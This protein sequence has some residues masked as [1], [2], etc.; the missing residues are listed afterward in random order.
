MSR[1]DT[2]SDSGSS[3]NGS[4]LGTPMATFTGTSNAGQLGTFTP[5]FSGDVKL[6]GSGSGPIQTYE[7]T[8]KEI[9]RLVA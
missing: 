6:I 8:A 7:W 2:V 1:I 5:G 3:W 9:F 4:G